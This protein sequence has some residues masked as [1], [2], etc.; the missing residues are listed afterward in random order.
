MGA[1]MEITVETITRR[2]G[3]SRLALA[4]GRN[5]SHI[6][7]VLSG[8]RKPGKDLAR[9]LARLGVQVGTGEAGVGGLEARP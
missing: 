6:S 8:E 2:R 5:H 3:V 9:R 4:V 7:R 1:T